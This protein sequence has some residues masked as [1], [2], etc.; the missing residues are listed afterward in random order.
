MERKLEMIQ[1]TY[2]QI[3]DSY[4]EMIGAADAGEK[5]I[6]RSLDEGE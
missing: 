5:S 2:R 6:N 1:D 4:Y 3:N